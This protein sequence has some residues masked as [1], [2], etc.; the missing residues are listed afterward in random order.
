MKPTF[1]TFAAFTLLA[2]SVVGCA[3]RTAPFNEMDEASITVLQLQG[4]YTPPAA[5]PAPGA[6][7]GGLPQ[8]IPGLPVPPELQ[9][10]GQQILQGAQ[11]ALPGLIPPGLIPGAQPQPQVTP[12]QPPPRLF[13]NTYVIG[14]ERQLTTAPDDEDL[15]NQILDLFGDE[16]SFSADRGNCFSP[17]LGISMVRPTNPV[18]VDVMVSLS[19]NQ[20]VGDGFRWP[21]PVNGLTAES[22]QKLSAIYQQL[23]GPVP[24]GA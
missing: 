21:Y 23:F 2:P 24:P 14:A 22:R 8:L 16:D 19:C 13:K 12:A 7:A 11:Q 20:A 17:G 3:A 9:Q 6:P 18:P 1:W 10:M 15:R 4:Q 5:V